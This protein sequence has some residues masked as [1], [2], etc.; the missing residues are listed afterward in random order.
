M[1]LP[2]LASLITNWRNMQEVILPV[3]WPGRSR[4]RPGHWWRPSEEP[5]WT[6]EAE[7]ATVWTARDR[8][9]GMEEEKDGSGGNRYKQKEKKKIHSQNNGRYKPDNWHGLKDMYTQSV[10]LLRNHWGAQMRPRSWYMP[11]TFHTQTASR[12]SLGVSRA[13]CMWNSK[14]IQSFKWLLALKKCA[15]CARCCCKHI[16][17]HIR[18]TLAY[19]LF[20]HGRVWENEPLESCKQVYLS[21]CLSVGAHKYSCTWQFALPWPSASY[22]RAEQK[23]KK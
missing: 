3:D 8:K 6:G 22:Q 9:I 13:S 1:L 23:Q 14:M 18:I 4:V 12:V 19:T 20:H 17:E 11:R 7:P 21:P 15:G 10:T 2:R 5:Y 16:P